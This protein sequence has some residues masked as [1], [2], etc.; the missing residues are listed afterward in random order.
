MS[1]TASPRPP[2]WRH[3]ALA[4]AVALALPAC[5]LFNSEP[6]IN[7]MAGVPSVSA[8]FATQTLW[9]ASVGQGVGEFYS[10]LTPALE[11][12][13]VFA[14]SRDGSV[15]AFAKESG[16][17]LWRMDLSALPE[18]Q[19]KRSARLSGGVVARYGKLFIGSENG[20]L[21]ALNQA[22]GQLLWQANVGGEIVA[23][24]A[25]DEGKV[26]VLTAAGTLAAFDTDAGKQQWILAQEQPPLT[27]RSA[28]NPIITNSAVIYGRADGKLG[29]VL[30]ASGQPVRNSKVADARGATELD[31]MVDVDASPLIADDELYGIAYNGQLTARKLMNGDEVWKRKYSGASDMA[32]SGSVILLTDSQS[33][34]YAVDRRTGQEL[35]ANTQLSHRGVTAPVLV[36]ESVVV[37]DSEGYVYWLDRTNGQIARLERV[38]RSGFYTA[39]VV[40]DDVLY[41]QSRDG[42]LYA[43]AR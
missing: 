9:S 30:L 25:V 11:D 10:Q 23:R 42:S 38:D 20:Q 36:G 19:A 27:L 28:S 12:S 43:I 40:N 13:N 22:D 34:L 21:Y 6:D 33:H 24:P 14:A 29:I 2:V 5:S 26:V 16:E 32:L 37:A 17:R 3:I 4:A 31:R 41:L 15:A 7:P 35:W 39:P 1:N 18:N 8:Q